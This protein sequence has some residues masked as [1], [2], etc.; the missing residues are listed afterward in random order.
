MQ[1]SRFARFCSPKVRTTNTFVT[2]TEKYFVVSYICILRETISNS[3]PA[4]VVLVSQRHPK[5]LPLGNC[6]LSSYV[7]V[8]FIKLAFAGKERKRSKRNKIHT[9][10]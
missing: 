6:L 10:E 8:N 3:R 5:I 9:T 1:A 4:Q 2:G 7:I